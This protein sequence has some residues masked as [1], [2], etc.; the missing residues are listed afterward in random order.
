ML[1]MLGGCI[2]LMPVLVSVVPIVV[3][4]KLLSNPK[5]A[6]RVDNVSDDVLAPKTKD[7]IMNYPLIENKLIKGNY[8]YLAENWEIE[9][10]KV[11]I[12]ISTQ[13]KVHPELETVEIWIKPSGSFFIAGFKEIFYGV[14]ILE[15][16]S[17]NETKLSVYGVE[18]VKSEIRKWIKIICECSD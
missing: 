7:Q 12:P 15:K 4:D 14:I 10:A 6:A 8:Q 2:H 18:C 1:F 11:R 9:H 5:T 17:D 3:N 16:I 13:I